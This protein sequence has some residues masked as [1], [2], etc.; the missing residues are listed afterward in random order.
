MLKDLVVILAV[1]IVFESS[2]R[3][4][5]APPLALARFLLFLGRFSVLLSPRGRFRFVVAVP[6]FTTVVLPGGF[7]AGAGVQRRGR[8]LF[9][10]GRRLGSY[11]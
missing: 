8:F 7:V 3:R 9:A 6:G 1:A 10:G 11:P 5:A 4:C 2:N